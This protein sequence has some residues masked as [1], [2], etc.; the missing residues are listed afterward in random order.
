MKRSFFARLSVFPLF[1]A[2]GAPN[3]GRFLDDYWETSFKFLP[4]KRALFSDFCPN[5]HELTRN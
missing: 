2:T 1:M 4:R 5:R 3:V